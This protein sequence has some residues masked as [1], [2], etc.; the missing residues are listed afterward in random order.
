MPPPLSIP[1]AL[2]LLLYYVILSLLACFGLHRAWLLLQLW[3]LRKEPPPESPL[4]E[5]PAVLVQLPLYNEPAVA[6]RLIRACAALE[7]P[8][9]VR[10]Q[11][12]DD[13]TDETTARVAPLREELAFDH[14]RRGDRA[15]FKA[16]ALAHG[17]EI[18]REPVIALFDADFVPPRDFLLR[19]VPALLAEERTAF[20]QARWGHLNAGESALT[21][22][23]AALLDGHF[24]IEHAA[25]DRCG[26]VFNFNGTAGV[27]KR[28]AI[29]EAGGWQGETLTEDFDLSY[30]A[31]L[32]GW[33]GRFLEDP[34]V[35]A[36]LPGGW[37]ALRSQQRRWARGSV[38]CARKLLGPLW[39]SGLPPAVKLEAT[40][41]LLANL[42]W[43]LLLGLMLLQWPVLHLRQRAGL[44]DLIWADAAL[45]L[46]ATGAF[47]LAY[48]VAGRRAG[49]GW[50]AA[51]VRAPIGMLLG[52][53]LA[54]N[55]GRAALR[56]LWG[57]TGV[58][59]RTPKSGG[60]AARQE[61]AGWA[62]SWELVLLLYLAGTLAWTVHLG[63]LE[64]LP[65]TIFFAAGA[66]WGALGAGRKG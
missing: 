54:V 62:P 22:G 13:S 49:L 24:L 63:V 51:L 61:G 6:E 40:V 45:L 48:A 57:E 55:N 10:L 7:Y 26:L 38:Q 9:L 20:V 43:V 34:A 44:A 58:F 1:E 37:G 2:L 35:P 56:G 30:R 29:E 3:L 5:W 32:A 16:G 47:L 8:G 33:R 11:V 39:W 53:A 50:G 31:H 17:L 21:R 66:L 18:S 25:R 19:T 12:L 15:G 28:E 4:G 59:Q 23:Q 42:G 36:E 41:P 64:A 52:V 14:V 60:L 65:F 27:W 46:P